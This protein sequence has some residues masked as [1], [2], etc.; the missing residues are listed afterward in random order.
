MAGSTN[1]HIAP[2]AGPLLAFA[3]LAG[4]AVTLNIV[5]VFAWLVA[6]VIMLAMG[7]FVLSLEGRAWTAIQPDMSRR[8]FSPVRLLRTL[9]A[10]PG[11]A[12]VF[13]HGL[14]MATLAFA[15]FVTIGGILD[16]MADAGAYADSEGRSPTPVCLDPLHGG[17]SLF[18]PFSPR[19]GRQTICVHRSKAICRSPVIV[20]FYLQCPMCYLQIT[21][22]LRCC[23]MLRLH[24]CC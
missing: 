1:S 19:S 20:S 17:L 8:R 16:A 23:W 15:A 2:L 14:A 4:F 11:A 7:R 12:G 18:W 24:H 5:G 10:N 9:R 13:L 21:A 3:I 6:S 22:C